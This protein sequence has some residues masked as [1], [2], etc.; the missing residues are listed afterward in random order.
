[1]KSS[2]AGH[3]SWVLTKRFSGSSDND[4]GVP[5]ILMSKASGR[6]LS[7]YDWTEDALRVP[8]Y[9]QIV[10]LLPLTDENREN[11]MSQLGSI[12]CRLSELRFNKIGSLFEDSDGNYFVGECL[13]PTLLWQWRDRLEVM[14]RGPFDDESQ[15]F[16][17]QISAMVEHAKQLRMSP[18]SFFAPIPDPLEYR[19]WSDYREAT[20]LWNDFCSL[21]DKIESSENRLSFCIAGQLLRDMIPSLASTGIHFA[22]SHPDLHFGNLFV[23][24]EFN[25]TSVIDWG[26][27]SVGPVTELLVTPG[28][29]GSFAPPPDSLIVAFKTAFQQTARGRSFEPEQWEKAERI[30]H[31]TPLVRTLSTQDLTLFQNLYKLVYDKDSDDIRRDIPRLFCQHREEEYA[32]QLMAELREDEEADNE[33]EQ[34]ETAG[35]ETMAGRGTEGKRIKEGEKIVRKRE[36]GKA[37]NGD[38]QQMLTAVRKREERVT[39]RYAVARKLTLMS[40]RNANFVADKRLWQW[41]EDALEIVDV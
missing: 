11:I 15:Y 35:Q 10:K 24:D 31:F 1:M 23:D 30:R 40:E 20:D 6:P 33:E 9:P 34:E 19:N 29:N 39:V 12:M 41:I 17:S 32:K 8:G 27:A 3:V 38:V 7:E 18:H 28:F 37:D 25:I 26:S 16:G 4:I 13:S 36:E 2:P 14:E 5:Y 22:L 21:G